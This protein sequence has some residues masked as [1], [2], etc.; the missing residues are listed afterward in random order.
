MFCKFSKPKASAFIGHIWMY[1]D[2]NFGSLPDK[3]SSI[4]WHTLEIDDL[5]IYATNL[6]NTMSYLVKECIPT[7][8]ICVR[9]PEPPWRTTNLKRQIR[10]RVRLY[11]KAKQTN[12]ERQWSKFKI[13]CNIINTM[14]HSSKQHYTTLQLVIL[15][16]ITLSSRLVINS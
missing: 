1:K 14:I 15:I 16:W 11:R 7:I 5:S 3:A 10:K 4:D 8:T 12:L 6:D 2:G 13:M 9:T